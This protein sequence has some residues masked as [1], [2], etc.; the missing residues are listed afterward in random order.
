[1]KTLGIAIVMC[2]LLV[3][4][5]QAEMPRENCGCGLGSIAFK[6][7]DGLVFQ[8][9]AATTNGSFGNQ[10]FGITSGT[11]ECKQARSFANSEQVQRFVADNLDNLAQDIASGHG[12]TLDALAELLGVSVT[13]RPIFNAAL[14]S[15]FTSIFPSENVSAVDVLE[16]IARVMKNT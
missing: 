7:K 16:S 15:H 9:L 12:E 10:T 8:V 6:G 14:H 5:A 3:S 2:L 11:L 4:F 13:E 1:M